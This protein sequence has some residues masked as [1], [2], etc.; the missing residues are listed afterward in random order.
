M[1]KFIA[2]LYGLVAYLV[3]FGSFLYAIGF[4]TGIAVP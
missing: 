1:G 2:F 3:F 4:V